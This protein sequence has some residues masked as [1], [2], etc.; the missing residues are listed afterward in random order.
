MI[1]NFHLS[2]GPLS[3][4]EGLDR[5][6]DD[7]AGAIV[8]K[9]VCRMVYLSFHEKK[10]IRTN[11]HPL[12][13]AFLGRAWYLIA[14]AVKYR[15]VRTFKLGRIRKLT[16][17]DQTFSGHEDVDTEKHFGKAWR[18]IPEGRLYQ[19]HLRFEPQVAG[20]V[21]EV[22]WHESQRVEWHDDGHLDFRVTVDGLGEITWWILGYGDQVEVI[23]PPALRKRVAD[24]AA[25]V[26]KKYRKGSKAS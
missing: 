3:R 6:F 9:K 18:M 22:K 10:Q 24:V 1:D 14:Y 23:S 16:P 8:G 17:T 20:N 2:F 12:R 7:L 15:D 5:M 13:L 4:H 25:G 11:V 19:V 21:A 26:V